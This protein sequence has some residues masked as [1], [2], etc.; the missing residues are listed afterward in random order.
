MVRHNEKSSEQYRVSFTDQRDCSGR[1]RQTVNFVRFSLL[2]RK[3]P[4]LSSSCRAGCATTC[5]KEPRCASPPRLL[6]Q[7]LSRA[8]RSAPPGKSSYARHRSAQRVLPGLTG[9][10]RLFAGCCPAATP[11]DKAILTTFGKLAEC[12][13]VL[14]HSFLAVS[15]PIFPSKDSC[16]NMF[17]NHSTR[18]ARFWIDQLPN[19][20]EKPT[21]LHSVIA[22]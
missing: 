13:Q 4:F 5:R 17:Q 12:Y 18:F 15:K 1:V 21:T 10:L 20:G 14:E 7:A 16:C 8:A 11:R 19:F 6:R 3:C 2:T 22:V 9:V